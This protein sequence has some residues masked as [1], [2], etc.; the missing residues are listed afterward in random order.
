[1]QKNIQRLAEYAS[2][3]GLNVRPHTKTHKSL[4]IAQMQLDH[5]A[6][7]LTVAKLGE[8]EVMANAAEDILLAYPALDPWRTER[9]AKLAAKKTLRVAVDS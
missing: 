5:G 9:L 3:N 1:M 7:G 8:A 4:K 6:S 2:A